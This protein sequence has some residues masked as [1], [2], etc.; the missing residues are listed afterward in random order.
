MTNQ[1]N[2]EGAMVSVST[3]SCFHV[4]CS[5]LGFCVVEQLE[6]VRDN[7]QKVKDQFRRRAVVN[8]ITVVKKLTFPLQD[9]SQID[10]LRRAPYNLGTKTVEKIREIVGSGKL[11]RN[12]ELAKNPKQQAIKE[13]QGKPSQ[14]ERIKQMRIHK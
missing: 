12:L 11:E 3:Q 13:N 9:D 10:E 14:D 5:W 8:G 2:V 7:Y 1:E 4:A 6:E